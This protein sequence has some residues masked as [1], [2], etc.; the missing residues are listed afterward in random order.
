MNTDGRYRDELKSLIGLFESIVPLR[1]KL[2][3]HWSIHQLVDHLCEIITRTMTYSYFP[4]QRILHQY[5]NVSKPVF[6]NIS[7]SFQSNDTENSKNEMIV[8]DTHLRP[9]LFP[10]ESI[11][12]QVVHKFD[13][14]LAIHHDININKLSCTINASLDLFYAETVDKFAQRFLSMLEHLFLS[15]ND[16]IKKSVYE[17]SLILPDERLLMQSMNNTQVLFPF[18]SCIN[19]EFV[20]QTMKYPQKLAVELD[21]QSL[22]YTELLYYVQVLSLNLLDVFRVIPGEII[23]QYVERSLS[24]VRILVLK[25]LFRLAKY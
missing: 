3:P 8:G 19:Y 22:T 14:S 18:V 9:I 1:C 17:L 11:T 15:T 6:L 4:L 5:P 23:C 24:M 7:F 10:M 16:Q 2:D 12:D 25:S 21:D 13:F 20:C